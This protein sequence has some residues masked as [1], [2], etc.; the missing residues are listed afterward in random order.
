[1]GGLIN[2]L[3]KWQALLPGWMVYYNPDSKIQLELMHARPWKY[4]SSRYDARQTVTADPIE[5][6]SVREAEE[7][8]DI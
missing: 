3:N 4:I 7:K 2:K 6:S 1:M 8:M 5:W